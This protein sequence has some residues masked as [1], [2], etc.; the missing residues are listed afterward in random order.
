MQLSGNIRAIADEVVVDAYMK[1]SPLSLKVS[2]DDAVSVD[3]VTLKTDGRLEENFF[4]GKGSI[5]IEGLTYA[6]KR[7]KRMNS[8]LDIALSQEENIIMM[9]DLKL[10]SDEFSASAVSLQIGLSHNGNA[11]VVDLKGLDTFFRPGETEITD[12]TGSIHINTDKNPYLDTL[13]FSAGRL[14]FQGVEA[15]SVSG[16]VT[17]DN[18]TFYITIPSAG[19][20][21]GTVQFSAQ[22]SVEEAPFPLEFSLLADDIDLNVLSHIAFDMTAV[23]YTMSG[24]A[25]RI[26]FSG[27]ADSEKTIHGKAS[28]RAQ[29]ITVFEK[30]MQRDLLK[31]ISLNAEMVFKGKDL[32]M[33]A[34][35]AAGNVR[36]SVHG[37]VKEYMGN[38]RSFNM[39][40]LLPEVSVDDVRNTFWDIL[41]D[42]LLYAGLKGAVSAETVLGYDTGG[43]TIDGSLHIKEFAFEEE[44]GTYAFGPVN[45]TIPI[46]FNQEAGTEYEMEFPSFDRS[47]FDKTRAR[48]TRRNMHDAYT[49]ISVGSFRYGFRIIDNVEVWVNQKGRI[50]N[51][52]QLSGSIF[53]G[54][55]YG[56]AVL[57]LTNG[58]QYKTGLLRDG[59]SLKAVCDRIAPIKGYLTGRVSGMAAIKGTGMKTSGLT[60]KAEFWAYSDK[61]EKT[62][63]SKE[64]LKKIGGPSVK[65]YLGD[66]RFDK[67]IMRTY[68]QKGFLIFNELEISNRNF[69]GLTDMSIKVAPIN[70]RI[71]IDH[72]MW[73]LV[74]TA[75][76]AKTDDE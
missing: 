39:N 8:Q 33:K 72:L 59:L 23:P 1:L 21:G 55:L 57:D 63:I 2:K 3:A 31:D 56:S 75:Q 40:L 65:A 48:Y 25:D 24:R 12:I 71:A 32:E 70:N 54:K 68:M 27:K 66:R 42:N 4:S 50:L 45:G 62:K 18:D 7:I 73:T 5:G 36:S 13:D 30:D 46:S 19:I 60:G 28:L 38:D 26:S 49:R 29:K 6:G 37:V 22:S 74:E 17:T 61:R 14:S 67:G 53:G 69:I 43:L 52:G 9:N 20:A 51:I 41:P 15:G 34:D 64:F 47:R 10:V 35:T 76:R 11:V 16:S 44:F 58:F